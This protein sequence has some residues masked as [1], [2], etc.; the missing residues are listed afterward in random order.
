M[1]LGRASA[2]LWS[3]DGGVGTAGRPLTAPWVVA[4]PGQFK[5]T[6]SSRRHSS[7]H[8]PH[9]PASWRLA[10]TCLKRCYK[11]TLVSGFLCVCCWISRVIIIF[12]TGVMSK[13]QNNLSKAWWLF[14]F[15]FFSYI[16]NGFIQMCYLRVYLLD[17]QD[18]CWEM[19][20]DS[21]G[22]RHTVRCRNA[23]GQE[24]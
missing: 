21:S 1:F 7:H 12:F 2:C 19:R 8:L 17:M 5:V 16:H 18:D 15:S 4:L 20:H 9:Q 6:T 22:M 3:R 24:V 23:N 10:W 11:L 13:I 14:M